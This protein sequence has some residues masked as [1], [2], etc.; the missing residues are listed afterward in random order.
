ML[1]YNNMQNNQNVGHYKYPTYIILDM[2]W[3]TSFTDE[4]FWLYQF[5]PI[6]KIIEII[7]KAPYY[8]DLYDIFWAEFYHTVGQ[9]D[10]PNTVESLILLVL[11]TLAEQLD[12]EIEHALG[13]DIGQDYPHY[14]QFYGW[15]DNTKL[16][17][18]DMNH[19]PAHTLP[20]LT[21]ILPNLSP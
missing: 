7:L 12:A 2:T 20:C 11:E 18:I 9:V 5:L 16:M 4:K 13:K 17:L 1:F 15:I 8:R 19:K 3:I 21:S 6:T 14:Y 10:L